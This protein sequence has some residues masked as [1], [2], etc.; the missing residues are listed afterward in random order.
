MKS[1]MVEKKEEVSKTQ[2]ATL[3]LKAIE[4]RKLQTEE[5]A[6]EDRF[7]SPSKS[8]VLTSNKAERKRE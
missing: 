6:L 2:D 7:V 4:G 1:D 8:V 5:A 3:S